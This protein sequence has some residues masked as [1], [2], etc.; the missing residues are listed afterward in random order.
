ML[1]RDNN[2]MKNEKTKIIT[3]ES[4]KTNKQKEK[5]SKEGPRIREPFVQTLKDPIKTDWKACCICTGPGAALCS[6]ASVSVSSYQHWGSLRVSTLSSAD[7]RLQ[8]HSELHYI[9]K[10]CYSRDDVNTWFST[11]E[12]TRSKRC[13]SRVTLYYQMVF[14]E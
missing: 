12:H 6:P 9:C 14:T 4:N 11:H 1:L 5:S 10:L 7:C 2:I 3:P 13:H 8:L